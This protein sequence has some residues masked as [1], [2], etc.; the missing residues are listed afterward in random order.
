MCP[1]REGTPTE[2]EHVRG[3][4][5]RWRV[6]AVGVAITGLAVV[7]YLSTRRP[8]PVL[9]ERD[10]VVI[11]DFDNQTGDDVFDGTL[12]QALVSQMGQSPYLSIVSE[13]R[14]QSTLSSMARTSSDGLPRPI[15]R[16]V[17]QR[18]GGKALLIGSIGNL[19][20][21][22]FVGLEAIGCTGGE[23]LANEY[24]EAESR[25]RVL[26]ALS[27]A[28]SK[29]RAGLGESLA[30]VRRLSAPAEATTPSLEAL[31]AYSLALAEQAVGNNARTL[32]ERAIE[33]DPDFAAPYLRLAEMY[34][35]RGEEL[36]AEEAISRV[37]A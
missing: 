21:R 12:R 22:Y 28:V 32:F 5:L 20:N 7:G 4:H 24:E 37:F 17:C 9:V 19:G 31:R 34:H 16:E 1:E 35:Y 15:A 30:S 27:R 29:I 18:V 33:L 36:R 6:V 3:V 11:A 23:T 26:A 8:A 14:I 2:V 25:E 13:E 10:S